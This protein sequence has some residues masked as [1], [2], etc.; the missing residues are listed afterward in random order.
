MTDINKYA[1][2][3]QAITDIN[4]E[5][6]FYHLESNQHFKTLT[7]K[8]T[9]TNQITAHTWR[10]P[11]AFQRIPHW[12]NIV[13]TWKNCSMTEFSSDTNEIISQQSSS[14]SNCHTCANTASDTIGYCHRIMNT[15]HLWICTSSALRRLKRCSREGWQWWIRCCRCVAMWRDDDDDDDHDRQ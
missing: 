6:L 5:V 8:T 2:K 7:N 4:E 14:F 12:R 9:L 13:N 11:I 15:H 1:P 3:T 10:I